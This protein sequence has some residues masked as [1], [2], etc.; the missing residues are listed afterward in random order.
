[1]NQSFIYRFISLIS[2]LSLLQCFNFY[3][4]NR[5]NY[6]FSSLTM[7]S[8]HDILVRAL[9]GESVER[10]PVWLMR[11]VNQNQQHV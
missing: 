11:Q 9:K 3:R 6:K 2:I 7:N 10:T 8:E 5:Y 4:N 1:M